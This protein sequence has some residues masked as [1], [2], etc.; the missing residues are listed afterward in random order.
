MKSVV[1]L[2]S[3]VLVLACIVV[4]LLA[5]LPML[6]MGKTAIDQCNTAIAIGNGHTAQLE[7]QAVELGFELDKEEGQ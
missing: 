4:G 5:A 6:D 7:Q 3:I 1:W 2:V